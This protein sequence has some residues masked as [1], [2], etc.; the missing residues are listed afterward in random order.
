[1]M[2]RHEWVRAILARGKAR[3]NDSLNR[4]FCGSPGL[5]FIS[6][7]PNCPTPQNAG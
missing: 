4:T 2:A 1:M 6:S 3:P 7:L 5:G